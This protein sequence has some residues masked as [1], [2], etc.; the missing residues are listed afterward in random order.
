M[1]TD[2]FLFHSVF[3]STKTDGHYYLFQCQ[4]VISF[5]FPNPWLSNVHWPFPGFTLCTS[6]CVWPKPRVQRQKDSLRRY[7]SFNLTNVKPNDSSTGLLAQNYVWP[8]WPLWT[9]S[10]WFHYVCV[11]WAVPRYCSFL[12]CQPLSN[13]PFHGANFAQSDTLQCIVQIVQCIVQTTWCSK[14]KV[15]WNEKT[16]FSFTIVSRHG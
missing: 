6:L 14:T 12:K 4:N 7:Y 8:Q 10:F 3:Q 13:C 16:S 11:A 1:V 15:T 9:H 5:E 2:L